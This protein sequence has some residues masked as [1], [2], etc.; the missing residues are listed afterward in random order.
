M[1]DIEIGKHLSRKTN[2][3]ETVHVEFSDCKIT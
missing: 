3:K 2:V 1:R